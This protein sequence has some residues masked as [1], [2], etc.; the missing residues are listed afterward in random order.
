LNGLLGNGQVYTYMRRKAKT[1]I[2]GCHRF[3][4]AMGVTANRRTPLLLPL[5]FL[6]CA[7]GFGQE[8]TVPVRKLVAQA[9][10]AWGAGHEV[11]AEKIHL[12]TLSQLEK[13]GS[14]D[15]QLAMVLEGLADLYWGQGRTAD[16][17]ALSKRVLAINEKAYGADSLRALSNL[18][19]LAAIY[20]SEK[21]NDEAEKY[22][23]RALEIEDRSPEARLLRMTVVLDN[24][25]QLYLWE[26]RYA[27]AEPLLERALEIASASP[28]ASAPKLKW[29]RDVLASVYSAE[30][31][32]A[33]A[34]TLLAEP[35][36]SQGRLQDPDLA[37][38]FDLELRAESFC[39][40]G[41]LDL[42]ETA[43]QQAAATV[44]KVRGPDEANFLPNLLED[45][46]KMYQ[47]EQRYAEAESVFKRALA[48]CDKA[49]GPKN[50][51]QVND[52]P[53]YRLLD[54]YR[55]MGRLSDI[56]PFFVRM[57]E[58]QQEYLGP[59]H[60]AVTRTLTIFATVYEEE[61]K[62]QEAESLYQQVIKIEE[63]NLGP[64][65]PQLA[66]TLQTYAGLLR[67][68]GRDKEAEEV[69]A[70]ARAISD[71]LPHQGPQP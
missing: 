9:R 58:L 65:H 38:A 48:L 44:E 10:E 14:E 33:Q 35:A 36:G 42:A 2:S 52:S 45:L 17:E 47:E 4:K 8:Q 12:S 27:D 20:E 21:R 53:L 5:L 29:R 18:N 19:N 61:G 32:E 62:Y 68:D 63:K 25:A 6:G 26:H 54:L 71:R 13:Q 49:P 51:G 50:H 69:E 67:K 30:G 55:E 40:Q 34:E 43:Y 70:R 3:S 59:E 64:S 56:E 24:L 46:G 39:K 11:E 31:K 23:K 60:S 28:Y 37:E 22:Y 1:E 41:S 16:A 66:G 15:P 7:L 57:L